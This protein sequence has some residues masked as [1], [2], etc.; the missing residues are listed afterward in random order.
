M[1]Q[2][3]AG[4]PSAARSR[5]D[6]GSEQG[7]PSA[8][9]DHHS[10]FDISGTPSRI[11]D[12]EDSSPASELS[13]DASTNSM[14]AR[15]CDQAA[16]VADDSRRRYW[17]AR[18]WKLW[19]LPPQV[20]FFVLAI[21][22]I[23]LFATVLVTTM[24]Q[25]TSADWKAFAILVGLGLASAEVTR[26]VER[27]RKKFSDTPHVNLS[28]VWTFSAA[29]LTAPTLAAATA[30]VLYLHLWWRTW[31]EIT[32]MAAYRAVFN[33]GVVVLS[34]FAATAAASVLPEGQLLQA[35]WPV[36]L[37][38]L[39]VVMA[40]YW[41]ANSLP[42]AVVIGLSRSDR[43][44]KR[45][46]GSWSDNAL[47]CAT[48]SLGALVAVAL[49]IRPELVV[50]TLLPLY[51]LHRSVLV[52]Q[53]EQAATTDSKTDLLNAISWH[54][55]AEQEF[56]RAHRHGGVCAVLMLDLDHFKRINDQHGHLVGDKV[57]RLAADAITRQA[58]KHD[59]AGRFGGEEFVVFLPEAGEAE[60]V[61]VA[62]RICAAIKAVAVI[63]DSGTAATI[64]ASVGVAAYPGAGGSLEELL[65]AADN[66][67][68]SA[69]NLGRDQVVS[70]GD[71]H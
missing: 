20:L 52:K 37:I 12:C 34:C 7:A 49:T 15:R 31:R 38:G 29:L 30:V 39:L 54:R 56:G 65:L 68:F 50:L 35:Q 62:E 58:R 53:L 47:E 69:K 23:G 67:L 32:G 5:R 2:D 21:E 41:V 57:L 10:L 61:R 25:V 3:D 16:K 59:I 13:D 26:H 63:G 40:V 28:S 70:V 46:V 51:V 1:Y 19:S 17:R 64:C 48:L 71:V 43:T 8:G 45:L 42:I 33:T 18:D 14:Q 24:H 11:T 4:E 6:A 9:A 55:L 27:V 36:G 22:L 60:G 44:V 66:A